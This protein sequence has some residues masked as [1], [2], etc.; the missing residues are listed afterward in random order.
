[1]RTL[2]ALIAGFLVPLAP[3]AALAAAPEAHAAS[4]EQGEPRMLTLAEPPAEKGP[5]LGF[6]LLG[7]APAPAP[8]ADDKRLTVR[9][10]ILKVHQGLGLAVVTLQLATTVLGQLNYHDRYLGQ[11]TNDF[12]QLHAGF[13]Y[14]TF[15]LFAANGAIA[16]LAPPRPEGER[17]GFDRTTL[18]K[19]SMLTA[20]A[21]MVAQVV[22][23]VI[24]SQHVGKADQR[25]LA[26]VHLGI[27]YG[28]L[29]ATAV[30]VGAIVF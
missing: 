4:T 1:M 27:G 9:R 14:A 26:Q 11:A 24:T 7:E 15:A 22:L 12:K 8:S 6:D 30:G 17:E 18:H 5:D 21:G 25:T 2:R 19:V 28:T 29:A 3:S 23:G 16:L 13:A 10:S 20:G